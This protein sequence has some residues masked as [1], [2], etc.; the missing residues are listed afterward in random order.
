VTKRCVLY[1][2]VSSVDQHVETQ[3][4]DLRQFAAQR[5]FEVVAEYT[6]QGVSGARARRPGL[7]AM[8]VD[9]RRRKFNVVLVAAFDR[10]ARSTKHFLTVVDEL[11]E[12]GIE[13]VSHRENI[14]TTGAM[15][16]M[17]LTVL[18]AISELDRSMI[19]ERIKAG[20]R[21]RKLEGYPLGRQPL[22]VDHAALVRDRF[23][24]LSLTK[25]AKKYGVSRASVVRF[26]RLAKKNEAAQFGAMPIPQQQEH[27]AVECASAR[28]THAERA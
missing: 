17:F 7:D 12:L 26:C 2:R 3:L 24:G 1:A 27:A 21:R 11:D 5:G 4:Y 10:L 16:R 9:A 25:T 6:D 23:N 14:D 18:G 15:G 28:R 19:V 8:L 22:D 13:F 20:M